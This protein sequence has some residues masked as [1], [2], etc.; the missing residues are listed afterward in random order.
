MIVD[1]FSQASLDHPDRNEDAVLI[2]KGDGTTAPVFAMIDGMGGHQR[3]T[4]TGQWITGRD[5]A[6][7]VRTVIIEDL[8]RLPV[9]VSAARGD[10]AETKAIAVLQRAHQ[11]L[12]TELNGAE[13]HP[14]SQRVGA[15]ATVAILCENGKRL[16]I[17]QVGDTRS[18][19]FS[20]DELIQ[21]V[22][23]EDNVAYMIKQGAL[24]EEDGQRITQI[25]NTFDGIHE[26]EV[27]GTVMLNG[28]PYEMYHVWRWFLAGNESLGIPGA[29]IVIK[30]L[31]VHS[32]DPNP[33]T[34]R[35]E[36]APGDVLWMC[37]DGIYKNLTEAE[38]IQHLKASAKNAIIAGEAAV[39]RSG[40][41]FNRRS[42][43]DDASAIYVRF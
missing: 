10:V 14:S 17:A 13:S 23:D 32:D 42:T 39:A 21:L 11:R 40:D 9:D 22:E 12:Y 6:Q 33:Q 5:A 20:G 25:L 43:K 4:A 29:N 8:L 18:Y 1:E 31:G 36:V 28:Q 24:S 15:V 26:P 3:E 34:S 27:S 41:S 16:V 30:S 35:M 37:S 7:M 19:L 2:F 38:M